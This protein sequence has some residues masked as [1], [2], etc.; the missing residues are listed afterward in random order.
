[1]ELKIVQNSALMYAK[2]TGKVLKVYR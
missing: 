1:M 2:G